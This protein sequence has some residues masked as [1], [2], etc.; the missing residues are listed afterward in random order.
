MNISKNEMKENIFENSALIEKNVDRL[1]MDYLLN[2]KRIKNEINKNKSYSDIYSKFAKEQKSGIGNDLNLKN[3][4]ST[5]LNN[6][7]PGI[8]LSRKINNLMRLNT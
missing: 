8:I 4:N 1:K 3:D 2:Y 6:N 5:Y 7:L